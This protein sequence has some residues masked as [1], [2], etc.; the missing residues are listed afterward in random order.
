M[1]YLLNDLIKLPLNE[2]LKVIE[3][4]INSF[5]LNET[6]LNDDNSAIVNRI[7]LWKHQNLDHVKAKHD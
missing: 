4:A 6:G 5:S 2:R 3:L 1:Q 7:K